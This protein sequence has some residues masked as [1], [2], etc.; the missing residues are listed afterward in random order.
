MHNRP[1]KGPAAHFYA[2]V[3]TFFMGSQPKIEKETAEA[4]VAVGGGG[5]GGSGGEDGGG[6]AVAGGGAAAGAAG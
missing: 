5:G 1:F 2:S 4:E 6:G 3:G